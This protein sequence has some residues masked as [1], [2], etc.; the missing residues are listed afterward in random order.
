MNLRLTSHTL[1]NCIVDVHHVA[2]D[3]WPCAPSTDEAV[4]LID[5]WLGVV[6][7]ATVEDDEPRLKD[8]TAGPHTELQYWHVR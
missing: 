7:R 8:P 4:A 6:R 5:D 3:N 2:G 1:V